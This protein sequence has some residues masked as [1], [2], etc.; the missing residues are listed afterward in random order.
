MRRKLNELVSAPSSSFELEVEPHFER[1][2]CPSHPFIEI[3]M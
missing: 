2:L 1:E 3:L